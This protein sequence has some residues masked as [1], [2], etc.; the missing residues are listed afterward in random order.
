ML[1]FERSVSQ[2]GKGREE[3]GIPGGC[4][5]PASCTAN[6]WRRAG[7]GGRTSVATNERVKERRK[8]GGGH[9]SG[10]CLDASLCSADASLQLCCL[11]LQI[12]DKK[13]IW[14]RFRALTPVIVRNPFPGD[15]R[16][17]VSKKKIIN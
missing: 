5:S 1:G 14:H 6:K 13:K 9:F 7:Y 11:E 4:S 8:A 12:E 10:L 2:G 16:P 17:V 3:A 15:T